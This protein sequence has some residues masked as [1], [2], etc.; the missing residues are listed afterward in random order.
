MLQ[1]RKQNAMAF[2]DEINVFRRTLLY[3]GLPGSSRWYDVA[4]PG[5]PVG[6]RAV[7]YLRRRDGVSARTFRRF[8]DKLLLA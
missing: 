2:K 6:S 3:A 1:G 4:T 7:I 8:V 5:E